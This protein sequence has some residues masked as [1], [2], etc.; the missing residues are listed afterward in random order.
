[1]REVQLVHR[2]QLH[3]RPIISVEE[4]SEYESE[5]LG[6]SSHICRSE[7]DGEDSVTRHEIDAINGDIF[8]RVPND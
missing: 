1:M 4:L 5:F 2:H 8:L 6:T 3:I 7:C